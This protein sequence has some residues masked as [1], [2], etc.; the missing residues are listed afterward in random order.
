MLKVCAADVD[1]QIMGIIWSLFVFEGMKQ[2]QRINLLY[3]M[4]SVFIW[5]VSRTIV[6]FLISPDRLFLWTEGIQSWEPLKRRYSLPSPI[7]SDYYWVLFHSVWLISLPIGYHELNSSI[8]HK[9]QKSENWEREKIMHGPD[10]NSPHPARV[11]RQDC[12][13]PSRP[14]SPYA[15]YP[16]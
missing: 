7:C 15:L 14:P 1:V 2:R 9:T 5:K 3:S 12:Q 8:S 11:K 13:H 4:H 6:K 10:I 16:V